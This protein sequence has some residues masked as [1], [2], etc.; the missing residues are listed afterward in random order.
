M[1]VQTP[2]ICGRRWRSCGSSMRHLTAMANSGGGRGEVVAI[3][4][5]R[6]ILYR[7][8]QDPNVRAFRAA[9]ADMEKIKRAA[10]LAADIVLGK[11]GHFWR[12]STP[13][14]TRQVSSRTTNDAESWTDTWTSKK[15]SEPHQPRQQ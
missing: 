5:N 6:F 12:R 10:E 2:W 11:V 13:T 4:G 8:F 3:H 14:P 9:S 1:T 7:V 15:S